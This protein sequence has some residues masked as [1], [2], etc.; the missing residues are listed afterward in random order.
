MKK[1]LTKKS[2]NELFSPPFL[3]FLVVD[4]LY[5]ISSIFMGMGVIVLIII[6]LFGGIDIINARIPALGILL[7]YPLRYLKKRM[8]KQQK[9]D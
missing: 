2:L 7:F 6:L 8:E 4:V 5:T 9:L 3:A 1:I